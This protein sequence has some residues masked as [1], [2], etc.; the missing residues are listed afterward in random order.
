LES[1][2]LAKRQALCS[3]FTIIYFRLQGLTK[4]F[5]FSAIQWFQFV[6]QVKFLRFMRTCLHRTC[7]TAVFNICNSW[8]SFHT[9]FL[10][11]WLKVF[12]TCHTVSSL[13]QEWPPFFFLQMH[14]W[15]CKVV[16]PPLY[17]YSRLWILTKPFSERPLNT[18]AWICCCILSRAK[19]LPYGRCAIF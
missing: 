4:V 3:G 2:L 1:C 8:L 16:K 9:D 10:G 14:P 11:L 5:L 6:N 18:G 7:H 12:P 15:F 13:T 17:Q 19:A